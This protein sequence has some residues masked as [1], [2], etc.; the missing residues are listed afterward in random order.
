MCL[1][2]K[3]FRL[4]RTLLFDGESGLRGSG[5]QKDIKSRFD[6]TL[7]AEPRYKRLMAERAIREIKLRLAIQLHLKKEPLTRWKNYFETT[8]QT[9][10]R[11]QEKTYRSI[12][13]LLQAYV[14]ATTSVV[15]QNIDHLYR[16]KVGDK[17]ALNV[18][19]N[20]RRQLGFKWS[21]NQGKEGD[22]TSRNKTTHWVF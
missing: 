14:T 16:Y 21:L 19:P 22:K 6:I 17:I 9:I 8:I 1:Q 11:H 12:N 15:P 18:S 7:H 5:V 13:Q 3:Q 2:D 20:Q 10:N 4:V